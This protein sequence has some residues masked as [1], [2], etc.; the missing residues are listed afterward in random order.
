[1][2]TM[3]EIENVDINAWRNGYKWTISECLRLEREYDLLKLSVPE[4]A[5]LHKRTINAILFKLQAEGL[6]TYNNLYF[7]TYG[8]TFIDDQIDKLN[9]LCSTEDL[10]DLDEDLDDEDLDEDLEDLENYHDHSDNNDR[11][12][13]FEHVKRIHKHVSNLLGYF[14]KTQ[15]VANAA[16]I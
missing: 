9:N 5:I 8:Q 11:T 7:K 10:E 6:D 1:M 4:M 3:E 2:T 14:T 16:C 15:S 13:I 12:F